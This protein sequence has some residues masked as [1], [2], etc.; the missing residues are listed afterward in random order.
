MFISF[1]TIDRI[2]HVLTKLMI[3]QNF[4]E[5]DL[6]QCWSVKE[7]YPWTIALIVCDAHMLISC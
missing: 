7:F 1:W 2:D 3:Q 5:N 4:D 6:L